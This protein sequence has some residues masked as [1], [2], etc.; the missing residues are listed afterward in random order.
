MDTDV[1]FCFPNKYLLR[2]IDIKINFLLF[3]L[4]RTKALQS[5]RFQG[6]AAHRYVFLKYVLIK[7]I[8]VLPE[9]RNCI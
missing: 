3:I 7:I 1:L 5:S 6:E 8:N 2:F 9:L 4:S